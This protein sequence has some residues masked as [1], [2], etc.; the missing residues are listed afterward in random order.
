[1]LASERKAGVG[2]KLGGLQRAKIAIANNCIT[3]S[4]I[5]GN[6]PLCVLGHPLC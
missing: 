1:L 6:V 5:V 2:R 3:G 4:L